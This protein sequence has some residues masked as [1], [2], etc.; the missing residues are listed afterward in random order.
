MPTNRIAV[1][2]KKGPVSGSVSVRGGS[3]ASLTTAGDSE[4][5]FSVSGECARLEIVVED[6][7]RQRKN[8]A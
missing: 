8:P 1:I 2:W 4:N 3:V 5:R 6:E 7:G